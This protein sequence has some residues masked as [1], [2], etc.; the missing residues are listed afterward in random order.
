MCANAA[1]DA[2]EAEE[3]AAAV[4][5]AAVPSTDFGNKDDEDATVL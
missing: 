2:V 1:P 3:K 5:A 4:V